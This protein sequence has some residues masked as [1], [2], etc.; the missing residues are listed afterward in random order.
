MNNADTFHQTRIPFAIINHKLVYTMFDKSI[1]SMG[2][3]KMILF[4]FVYFLI[5]KSV[6][7]SV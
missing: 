7:K 3:K 1:E 5:L 6:L 2:K 4:I